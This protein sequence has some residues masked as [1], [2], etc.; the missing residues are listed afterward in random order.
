[1]YEF[2]PPIQLLGAFD[3]GVP[4]QERIT[5]FVTEEANLASFLVIVGY[6]FHP[7]GAI[8]IDNG[9]FWF[10][11]QNVDAGYTIFLY[12]GKG[13]RRLTTV[14]GSNTPAL[15]LHWGRDHTMFNDR[16]IVPMLLQLVGAQVGSS[17]AVEQFKALSF[18]PS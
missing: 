16:N 1:M 10:G 14:S 6:Q 3:R 4:N 12:T 9:V 18:P 8:P 13:E 2:S 7:G 17:P 11:N 5:F 15:V